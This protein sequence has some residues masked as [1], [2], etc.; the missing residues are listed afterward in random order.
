MTSRR[1]LRRNLHPAAPGSLMHTFSLSSFL[2]LT[3]NRLLRLYFERKLIR[4]AIDVDAV[5]KRNIDPLLRAIEALPP[6]ERAVVDVD[7]QDVFTLANKTGYEVI[8][9]EANLRNLGLLETLEA[10]SGY[11]GRA[12][13]LFLN[14]IQ[15][16]TNLLD[17]CSHLTQV[18]LLTR[19]KARRMKNLPKRTP[20]F[21]EVT[22]KAMADLL[23]TVYRPQGRGY[24]CRVEYHTRA[25]QPRHCYCAYPEDHTTN[26]LGYEGD[27]LQ[28]HQRKPVFELVFLYDNE[29]GTLDLAGDG[30]NGEIHA[31]H[32]IFCS[33]ALEMESMP[34]A[35]TEPT[36]RLGGL[37]TATAFSFPTDPVDGIDR[38][39]VVALRM[40]PKGEPG[41]SLTAL[42]PKG[43]MEAWLQQCVA[44]DRIPLS[45]WEVTWAKFR[46]TFAPVDGK[47]AR[48]VLFTLTPDASSLQDLPLHRIIQRNLVAWN[49]M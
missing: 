16:G 29:A 3:P 4:I 10:E 27:A 11:Y 19:H 48:V 28:T 5:S 47:R 38:L 22:L 18:D 31:F 32:Q 25:E 2:R 23:R 36:Y 37:L 9:R 12:M 20:R 14:P 1:M 34:S 13:W 6:C 46:V 21:D 26:E 24:L 15:G 40:H 41:K 42:A 39:A 45:Q 49:L 30:L 8:L 7:F 17:L 33:T 44:F 35:P 43:D